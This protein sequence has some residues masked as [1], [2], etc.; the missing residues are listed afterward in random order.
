MSAAQS[1]T[2]TH[3]DP[4]IFAPVAP[5]LRR[6]GL[7]AKVALIAVAL[8]VPLMAT[9]ANLVNRYQADLSYTQDELAGTHVSHELLDLMQQLQD[10][11][12]LTGIVKQGVAAA[13]P[14]IDVT[15][16]QIAAAVADVDKQVQAHPQFELATAWA[17]LKARAV[18]L[19]A[20][21]APADPGE[22]FKAHTALITELHTLVILAAEKSGL[23]LDPEAASFLMMDIFIERSFHYSEAVA[24][25]R[26]IAAQALARGEWTSVDEAAYAGQESQM[27]LA[28][29][30]I[31]RRL[32]ALVRASEPKP[33]GWSDANQ[34]VDA[35]V[36]G[37]DGWARPGK[38]K[39]D[40][41][42]LFAQGTEAIEKIDVFH[43]AVTQRMEGLLTE[44]VH[45]I[46][47]QRAV[48]LAIT[49][50]AL[51]IA[52]YLFLVIRH[53]LQRA[54]GQ[55]RAGAERVAAGDLA[56]P[57]KVDGRD[58]FAAIA[59]SFDTV[60]GTLNRLIADMNNM[61]TEHERGD[62]DVVIDGQQFAG[63]YRTMAQGVNDMV[64]AHIA[65]KK[66]A[67]GVVAEFG[68]GNYDAPLE[69]LPG[70]KAFINDTIERVRGL[71]RDAATTA[72][73]NQRIRLALDGVPSA[74]MIADTDGQ[75]VYANHSVMALLR[76]I[77]ADLRTRLP[78]FSAQREK[79]IGANFDIFH[80]NPSHQRSL[81][82]GMTAP[83]TAQWKFGDKSV[84]L[85]AS[86]IN[87]AEGVRAGAV[88]EWVDRTAEVKAEEDIAALVQ[89]AAGGEFSRRLDVSQQTGFFKILGEG[90]NQLVSTTESNLRQV[91]ETINRVA[92]G[93][94]QHDLEGD[95]G[96]VFAQ[97]QSDLN[98]MSDQ[99]RSTISQVST[100]AAA[101]NSAAGQVSSTSQS[102]SQS[103]SEQAASVEET[104][105]SL[106]EMASSVKQNSD[107]AS[108]TDGMA[109]KAAREAGEGASA[110][111]RT[112][113]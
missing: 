18:K 76:G 38:V 84:R 79:I 3:R 80:K 35:L 47:Q 104:A 27:A 36:L 24:R 54:A 75:I 113:E 40:A 13:A 94:L 10:H 99:L 95:F 61:S 9:L 71:L 25:L 97:L 106:Q 67:M 51:V 34:A 21:E 45:R 48:I 2:S 93:D 5:L 63:D 4:W 68:R 72:Q 109:A 78:N 62:I 7:S 42:A 16:K 101:L 6:L 77:E 66:M 41:L 112:V 59:A 20:G 110:V 49:A 87:T 1:P 23:L 85:T 32:D 37:I 57:V 30:G 100:A 69:Q 64:G 8:L 22:S 60:R 12:G 105:A 65:V 83:H 90:M 19:A 39:G 111:A 74:V 58:E 70:K 91:G 31:Q 15:R 73:E 96:G 50:A 89:A 17:P 81:L 14:K 28:T 56:E 107:N 88:L 102:L 43:N 108:V 29:L 98:A 26:G 92:Q 11:R 44:R 53:S 46:E 55:L 52:I 103:S 33:A 86:P 82:A